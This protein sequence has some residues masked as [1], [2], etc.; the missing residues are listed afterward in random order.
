MNEDNTV[1]KFRQISNEYHRNA[2]LKNELYLSSPQDFNDPFDV[3][4]VENFFLV[5][6]D[7]K[8]LKLFFEY[9]KYFFIDNFDL[10]IDNVKKFLLMEFE[11]KEILQNK[12]IEAQDFYY[13]NYF[14]VN[15]IL[16][17]DSAFA[18]KSSIDN[19]LFKL[20]Q[21]NNE[22]FWASKRLFQ[23]EL[24]GIISFSK[25]I[26]NILMWSHYG[27]N[28]RGFAIGFDAEE[29]EQTNDFP[30]AGDVIY[31]NDFPQVNPLEDL[32][33]RKDNPFILKDKDNK[34]IKDNEFVIYINRYLFKEI[35]Y[36]SLDWQSEE[37]YKYTKIYPVSPTK[38]DRI[39]TYDK[40]LIKEVVLG[41]GWDTNYDNYYNELI[42]YCKNNNIP[43]YRM[44]P[45][46]NKFKLTKKI[47][48]I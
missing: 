44:C 41:Y 20:L 8:W 17:L 25:A 15:K 12:I 46:K 9:S 28:H 16:N 45:V 31:T 21:V 13:G 42:E 37:E 32:N 27:E 40:S 22:I 39:Y 26:N 10:I 38:K 43:M 47:M 11:S 14:S 33:F 1:Y 29:L 34:Y 36:K 3:V 7:K 48:T 23:F 4:N 35:F 24:Y 30:F 19:F 5:L 18:E 2:V 6:N